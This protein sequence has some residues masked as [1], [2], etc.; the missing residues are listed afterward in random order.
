MNRKCT[1]HNK[2]KFRDLMAQ[3]DWT[4]FCNNQ[5]TNSAFEM[6]HN[7]VTE[8]YNVAFPKVKIKSLY[9]VRKPWLT[10]GLKKS[11]KIKN[12]LYDIMSRKST[13]Y[14]ETIYKN[15]R[16]RLHKLLKNAERN[17]YNDQILTNRNNIRKTWSIIKT[18]INKIRVTKLNKLNS[19]YQMDR[20]R[21]ISKLLRRNSMIFL[22][23]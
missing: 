1:P 5:D 10:Y 6:F 20:S 9:Y 11:I 7:M 4:V 23:M 21:M 13:V 15:Y 14:N 18:I 8:V 16:N 19:C 17:Y 2:N 3:V 12:K 22:L